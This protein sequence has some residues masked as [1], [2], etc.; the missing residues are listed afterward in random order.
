LLLPHCWISLRC[1]NVYFLKVKKPFCSK[2]ESSWR[3]VGLFVSAAWCKASCSSSSEDHV[4][5]NQYYDD[6]VSKNQDQGFLHL[7]AVILQY[8]LDTF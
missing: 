1:K 6:Q 3:G 5:I 7:N 2:I 8:Y 4:H